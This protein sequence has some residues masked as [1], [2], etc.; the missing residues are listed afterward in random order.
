MDAELL[1]RAA[2]RAAKLARDNMGPSLLAPLT[3]EYWADVIHD[4]A[5]TGQVKRAG[6]ELALEVRGGVPGKDFYAVGG[7]RCCAQPAPCICGFNKAGRPCCQETPMAWANGGCG[8]A[9]YRRGGGQRRALSAERPQGA[10]V[11]T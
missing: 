11:T 5:N 1:S 7:S 6:R 4:A 3:E 9:W 8:A 2:D 10:T